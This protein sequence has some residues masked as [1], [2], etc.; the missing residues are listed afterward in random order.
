MAS[1]S[2]TRAP[3]LGGR[4]WF[5]I[6]LLGLVV[7]VLGGRA[8]KLHVV[9]HGFLQNRADRQHIGMM[10]VAAH[11]GRILDRQG[12][13]LAISTP[14]QSVWVNPQEFSANREQVAQ[15]ARV[16]GLS[17]GQV[18]ARVA[19]EGGRQFVYLKRRMD[20]VL[21]DEVRAL[22]L[23]GVNFEEEFRRYYP[24][25]EV[26]AH[27]LG[28]TDLNDRGQ[29]GVERAFDHHLAGV[30]GQR[31]VI[32]DGRQQVIDDAGIIRPARPGKD[33][34][35]N[36]DQRIQYLAYRALKSQVARHGAKA[37]SVV[38]LDAKKGD[39]L[40]MVN[41]PSF[42]P[43]NLKGAQH[44]ETR[45]R[46]VLDAYEPGSAMKP[47][48]VASA[49]E[50]GTIR[51]ENVYN[52]SPGQMMLG[53]HLVK[54]THNYGV[55]DVTG[56]LQKSSNVGASR[57]G[58]TVP[59]ERFWGFMSGLGFGESIGLGIPGETGGRLTDYR[60]W[61]QSGQVTLSYGYGVSASP[62]QLARAYL[63]LANEGVI[64]PVG[65][66]K[67]NDD[68]A[69]EPV[70][71]M[72]AQTANTVRTMLESVITREGTASRAGVDGY[73][74]AGKTGTVKKTSERGGYTDDSY[75]SV[76]AGLAPASDPRLVMVVVIDEPSQ[77]EYYGG[78]VA[79]PVFAEVM[80]GALRFL[81]VSPDE[82][83]TLHVWQEPGEGP[84]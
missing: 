29:E 38:V 36:L 65:L 9:D 22:G 13:L 61:G 1:V 81:N 7:V 30:A 77:G 69:A 47:F 37:G 55:L 83:S 45:N 72:S 19:P 78:L 4:W 50:M 62:L 70:R 73:R 67:D 33:L 79:A 5:V 18:A 20:P 41:Q 35:L 82:T 75:L 3:A 27:A 32:R 8:V 51:P 54:D 43:N 60:N 11:R 26:T 71:V 63:S 46:A 28:F 40:A 64:P 39:I 52:T 23:P 56:V 84:T 6:G 42:N 80:S 21:A 66:L 10:P 16:L 34:V 25:G 17:V 58:L 12:E 2:V 76:F 49:L 14:V 48:T 68:A 74:V 53:G 59:Q 31:R 57:I 24:T 15:L 44:G